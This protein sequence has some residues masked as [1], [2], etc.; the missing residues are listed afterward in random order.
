MIIFEA[1]VEPYRVFTYTWMYDQGGKNIPV[2]STI[3]ESGNFCECL[4]DSCCLLH[5]V[6]KCNISRL[7]FN[8][9]VKLGYSDGHQ[10]CVYFFSTT[11]G[12]NICFFGRYLVSVARG[13][14]RNAC[15]SSYKMGV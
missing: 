12:R 5:T 3:G 6:R 15:R 11:F 2:M 4:E 10:A 14:R 1:A 9:T 8:Q 13:E 7:L